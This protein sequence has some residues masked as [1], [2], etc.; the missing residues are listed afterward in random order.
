M[1]NFGTDWR[2]VEPWKSTDMRVSLL[3]GPFTAVNGASQDT[4]LITSSSFERRCLGFCSYL[5]EEAPKYR[6]ETVLLLGYDDRGD[7]TIRRR[8]ARHADELRALAKRI[9]IGGGVTSQTLD[10][11]N[12]RETYSFFAEMFGCL[13]KAS[14]VVVDIS[15]LT[16]ISLLYL[17][18]A[19]KESGRVGKLRLVYTRANYGRRDMLSWGAEEPI[20]LPGFGRPRHPNQKDIRLVLFCGLEPDRSYSIWRRFGQGSCATI[21]VGGDATDVDQCAK[22]AERAHNFIERAEVV[23][24]GAFDPDGVVRLLADEVERSGNRGGHV[25]VAPMTTKW[26]I[27]GVWRYFDGVGDS[28]SACVLYA[29]PGRLNASGRTLDEFGDCVMCSLW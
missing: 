22:R 12:I 8:V 18:K 14:S 28:V 1:W 11:Y 29:A 26:E 7:S 15:T 21:Y 13:P 5:Q 24:I 4:L 19:A 9:A 25:F 10:P 2:A 27:V 17:L 20:I 16:K 6:S 23:R 3:S